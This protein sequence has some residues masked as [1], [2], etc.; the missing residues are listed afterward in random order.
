MCSAPHVC[1]LSEPVVSAVLLIGLAL[2]QVRSRR[3]GQISIPPPFQPA[4]SLVSS[5]DTKTNRLCVLAPY[6]NQGGGGA[7]N[8]PAMRTIRGISDSTLEL[9]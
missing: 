5:L 7:T 3:T 6:S 9:L 8:I 4:G 2:G 1:A